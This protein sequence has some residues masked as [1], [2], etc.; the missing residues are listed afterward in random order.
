MD[1]TV[2]VAA[3][4]AILFFMNVQIMK[5]LP[6][7][8]PTAQ[9]TSQAVQPATAVAPTPID[10]TPVAVAPAATT[11]NLATNP[12]T[13]NEGFIDKSP[14]PY[15]YISSERMDIIIRRYNKKLFP[16]DVEKIKAATAKYCKEK[17]IDPRFILAPEL[18]CFVR[19]GV[20]DRRSHESNEVF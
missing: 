3:L 4:I 13:A 20:R 6:N 1:G 19:Q 17:D 7:N 11:M 14:A 18:D 10:P 5:P 15:Q 16:A 8:K 9:E 2:V 12:V